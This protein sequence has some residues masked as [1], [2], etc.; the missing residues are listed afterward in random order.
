MEDNSVTNK[1]M[2]NTLDDDEVLFHL[3]QYIRL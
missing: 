1:V 2:Q 3:R